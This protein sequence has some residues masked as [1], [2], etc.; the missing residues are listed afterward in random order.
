MKLP[1]TKRFS[2]IFLLTAITLI[3]LSS[4]AEADTTKVSLGLPSSVGVGVPFNIAI[5]VT[6][7]TNTTISFNKVAV[8]YALQDLKIKGPFE[9]DT[10]LHSVAAFSTAT[11][12]VT[13]RI[14]NG[15]GVIVPLTVVLANNNYS[16]NSIIGAAMGGVMVTNSNN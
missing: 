12:N 2:T 15:S 14:L 4:F 6:N 16:Q 8:A 5:S 9:V 10:S 3:I 13:F 11:I 1:R 7:Q